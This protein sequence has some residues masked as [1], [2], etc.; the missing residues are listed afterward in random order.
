MCGICGIINFDGSPIDPHTLLRMRDALAHRGPDD[1]G[2]VLI[3]TNSSCGSIKHF[4]FKDIENLAQQNNNNR[5]FNI[6]LAH[7]R[8]SIID[9]SSAGRQPMCNEDGSVW[10]T[11]NGEI[12]NFLELKKVLEGNGHIFKTR[13]DTEVIIHAYE[14]WGKD[15]VSHLRGM[16]AI[17][18]W[19]VNKRQCIMARDRFGI[20]PLFYFFDEK[21]LIF[22]SELKSL[23]LSGL[24]PLEI[25]PEAVLQY[26]K[27]YYIPAPNTIYKNIFS[28]LPAHEII[29]TSENL[30]DRGYW[31]LYF[32]ETLSDERKAVRFI[33]SELA[34]SIAQ[35]VVADVPVGCFLSGGVD[36]SLVSCY[37]KKAIGNDLKAYCIGFREDE[38]DESV[39]ARMVA[40]RLG[41][42]L[43][44]DIMESTPDFKDIMKIVE[45]C[46]QP[47]ADSSL[48]PTY[49]VCRN[50]RRYF[51]V[52]LSGD[53]GDEVFAGY[54]FRLQRAADSL[55]R[56][57]FL[58]YILKA[59]LSVAGNLGFSEHFPK[60]MER[61]SKFVK[62]SL[63]ERYIFYH[64]KSLRSEK[65]VHPD[66]MKSGDSHPDFISKQVNKRGLE[67]N[68]NGM[69]ALCLHNNLSNDMLVKVD[70][71][72]MANSLE[73]RVPF[74]DHKLV[75]AASKLSST[76]KQRGFINLNSKYLLKRIAEKKLPHKAIFRDKMGFGIP[77]VLWTEMKLQGY[78]RDTFA[79]ADSSIF[80]Y[81]NKSAVSTLIDSNEIQSTSSDKWALLC[82]F[83]W[84]KKWQTKSI[85]RG[86]TAEC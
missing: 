49:Q 42:D 34:E 30:I 19:D 6:G 25:N 44:V 73:V 14:E 46:D 35:H 13:S 59:I 62:L 16:F 41:I 23:A 36:S 61:L 18:I 75:E 28:V 7:R 31:Q 17:V 50:A 65:I 72:S 21:R 80:D 68:L 66:V 55:S 2:A 56:N 22:A 82:F 12:Y 38:Y 10:I 76:L 32:D 29:C 40:Q 15:F 81:L 83:I 74:L 67:N 33:E 71:A 70:R 45:C 84:Y 47:F 69:L 77:M 43:N 4:V 64:T 78:L 51:P 52:A 85:D 20:K 39:Y 8:L 1:W 27:Y 11:Y 53:G 57:S 63:P 79:N 58:D 26:F 86:F 9:L 54:S 24:V 5:L 37:A 48:I 60:G 3:N